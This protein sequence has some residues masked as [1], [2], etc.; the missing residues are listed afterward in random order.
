MWAYE[1]AIL[2]CDG[3]NWFKIAGKSL[4]MVCS[5]YKATNINFTASLTLTKCTIDTA[6]IDNTGA[7][8]DTSNNKILIKRTGSYYPDTAVWVDPGGIS[9][10]SRCSVY[11][12]KNGSS[13]GVPFGD[14]GAYLANGY[15]I[16]EVPFQ[17][18]SYAAGDYLEHYG[19]LQYTGGTPAMNCGNSGVR[20]HLGVVE[21]LTW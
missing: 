21:Q 19:V 2:Y 6:L 4:P 16:S 11:M 3:S 20:T 15:V 9:G 7:M 10:I 18:V 14:K 5:M 17:T 8:A 12:Y 13:S 1:T